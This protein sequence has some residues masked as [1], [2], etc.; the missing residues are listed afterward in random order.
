MRTT[1]SKVTF[2][3]P[4]TLNEDA[5]EL[6][7]GTYDVEVDEVEIQITDRT[8][9]RR[10]AVCLYVEGQ[11]STRTLVIHPADLEAALSR[12]AESGAGSSVS[13][14]VAPRPSERLSP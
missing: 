3:A 8:A 5:G 10:T 11:G 1:K 6:P 12:D 13:E 7:A 2:H 14:G 9:Y 4:F